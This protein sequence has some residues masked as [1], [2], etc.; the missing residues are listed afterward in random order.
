EVFLNGINVEKEIRG[1]EISD[2]V[3]GISAIATLRKRMVAK[4]RKFAEEKHIVMDGRDIGTTVFPNANLKIF[5]TASIE[6]RARRRY[7]ELA[8]KGIKMTLEQ[9][10]ENIKVRDFIDT[11]RSVSP[12]KKADDAIMLDNTNLT[13]EQQ[14]EWVL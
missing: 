1:K 13:R 14:L 5:M 6:V 11:T 7:D 9:V 2:A 12:L 10:K 4:Q 8:A 3:S